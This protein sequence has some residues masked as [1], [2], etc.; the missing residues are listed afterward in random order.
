[1]DGVAGGP[2]IKPHKN[3]DPVN[4]ERPMYSIDNL[5]YI[6]VPS[7]NIHNSTLGI[8]HSHILTRDSGTRYLERR[9]VN[10]IT[11]YT[12]KAKL[13]SRFM[14]Y[15]IRIRLLKLIGPDPDV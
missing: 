13:Q 2:A 8:Q 5:N 10:N 11:H 9:D 12:D 3:T 15:G 14:V 7:L 4:P 6:Y 1:M